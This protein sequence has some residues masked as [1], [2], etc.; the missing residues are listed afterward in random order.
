MIMQR[1]TIIFWILVR[2]AISVLIVCWSALHLRRWDPYLGVSLPAWSRTA[3]TV[4][5]LAG[6][7]TVLACGG[8]LSTLGIFSMP[9]ERLPPRKF[10]A[11]G[12]F[13]HVRN[14]MSLGFVI[15]MVG[16]GLY[17]SSVSIVLFASALFLFLHLVV[18][19]VEEPGLERRFG[20]SYWEYKRSVRR[21]LPRVG[22]N[23]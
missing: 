20:E 23:K 11:F 15:L 22:R 10:V 16:L 21:W 17:E 3:G 7:V 1:R 13:R 14:P 9:G 6:G 2:V 8:I 5:I 4:L 12:P 18:V 19:Y